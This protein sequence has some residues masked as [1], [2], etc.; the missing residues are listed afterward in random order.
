MRKRVWDELV[1]WHREGD[2]ARVR[3]ATRN[4][5]LRAPVSFTEY[6]GAQTTD[7]LQEYFVPRDRLEPMVESL[8]ALFT[9]SAA[10]V[11]VLSTT[12]RL[13]R[14]DNETVLSY[15]PGEARVCIAVDAEVRTVGDAPA[16]RDLDPRVKETLR[17]AIGHALELGGSYYLPYFRVADRATFE[18]AYPGH[19]RM[20]QAIDRYNPKVGGRRRYWNGFLQACFD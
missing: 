1:R 19:A 6:V 10:W 3:T 11:N 15:C 20:Q 14:S 13:V 16:R 18:R 9:A 2:D 17:T 7:I 8:R 12:L 4:D 5:W